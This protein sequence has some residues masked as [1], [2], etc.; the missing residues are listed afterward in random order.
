MRFMPEITAARRLLYI[1]TAALAL[2]ACTN[3]FAEDM[4]T[5][6]EVLEGGWLLSP[7]E[8]PAP[9]AQAPIYC[10]GTI[11]REDCYD[12]PQASEEGRL[13]GFEGPPPP[14]RDDL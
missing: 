13:I 10:Y 4:P 9:V 3:P 1:G 8:K 12:V 7:I 5:L 2:S 6:G 11:G 14:Q